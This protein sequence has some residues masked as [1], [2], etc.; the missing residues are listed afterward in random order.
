MCTGAW[1][2]YDMASAAVTGLTVFKMHEQRRAGEVVEESYQEAAVEEREKA[3]FEAAVGV[4]K[5][6]E[7]LVAHQEEEGRIKAGGGDESNLNQAKR[8]FLAVLNSIRIQTSESMGRHEGI[9][10]RLVKSGKQARKAA[11]MEALG[12]GISGAYYLGSKYPKENP[13]FG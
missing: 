7:A 8:Q 9:A 11:W 1:T 13:I 3:N 12:T 4:E 6:H 2:R 10:K 5:T